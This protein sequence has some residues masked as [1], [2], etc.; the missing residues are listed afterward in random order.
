[1]TVAT[2]H[3]DRLVEGHG[4]CNPCY[5]RARR[6]ADPEGARAKANA[7]RA[8]NIEHRRELERK[9]RDADPERH[10][11]TNRRWRATHREQRLIDERAYTADL[12]LEMIAAYGGS[13]AC[14]GEA[15]PA[16]LSLDHTAGGGNAHRRALGGRSGTKVWATLKRA[17]WPQGPY[18]VLCMNC[19]VATV[20]AKVCPHRLLRVVA[21]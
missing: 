5:R 7:Y 15:E 14:C 4:L 16:F 2:C 19:Q 9:Y 12:K 6:R 8:A 13:C 18:R 10:R 11:E 21:A 3:P 1:M 20:G 17:G